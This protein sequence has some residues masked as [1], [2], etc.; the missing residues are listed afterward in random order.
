[1]LVFAS[2][3][4]PASD[5]YWWPVRSNAPAPHR[6]RRRPGSLGP[7]APTAAR[8][9]PWEAGLPRCRRGPPGRRLPERASPCWRSRAAPAMSDSLGA[10]VRSCRKGHFR[11]IVGDGAGAPLRHGPFD[12]SGVRGA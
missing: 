3:A 5:P 10:A 8:W 1:M 6:S 4:N 9:P 7:V 11:R 2:A 12:R